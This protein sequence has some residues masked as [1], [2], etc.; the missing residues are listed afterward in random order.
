ME[1]NVMNKTILSLVTAM[2]FCATFLP[3]QSRSG[4]GQRGGS[5][6]QSPSMG[7]GQRQGGQMRS[8]A[9]QVTRQQDRDRIQATDQQ[10]DRLRTCDQT[11]DQVRT[12][13]RQMARDARGSQFNADQAR[14]QRDQ[15]REHLQTMQQEHEQLMTGLSAQQREAMQNRI[16]NM[17]Q[18]RESVNGQFQQVDAALNQDNP[19]AKLVRQRARDMEQ[20]MKEWQKQYRKMQ[21]EMGAE[22]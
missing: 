18:I 1:G 13:A 3:A 11:A 6:G 20:S 8:P 16:Q 5:Q 22:G 10:R 17:D 7:Q 19:D 12:Q 9:G 14:Q 4:G 2:A 21:S 15:I